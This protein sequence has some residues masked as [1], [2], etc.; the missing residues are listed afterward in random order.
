MKFAKTLIATAALAASLGA[1][2]QVVGSQ[3]GGTGNFLFL[4][5]PT[6]N[7]ATCLLTT[8]AGG[9]TTVASITGGSTL[10][11]DTF[12]ADRDA[13]NTNGGVNGGNFL[14]AGPFSTQ[15]ATL[16]LTNAVSY[17]SFLWGSPDSYNVLTVNSSGGGSQTFTA[18]TLGLPGDGNQ[19]FS[20]YVQFVANAGVTISSLVFNNIPAVNAFETANFS[21]V[22]AV[23]EPE[24]YALMLAGLGALGF[25]NR[26]RKARS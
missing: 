7:C 24:T 23:P 12:F 1:S 4:S 14:A 22:R 17:I 26:R 19:N 15:P 10:S 20:R 2:A 3:G 18:A 16:T 21:V 11:S 9:G 8:A 25:M 13:F 5:G 6:T